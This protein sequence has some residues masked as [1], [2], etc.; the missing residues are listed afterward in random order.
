MATTTNLLSWEDFEK[1]P[2]D[3]MRR[4][5]IRGELICL[6]PPMPV[7]EGLGNVFIEGGSKLSHHPP[8]WIQ[9]DVSFYRAEHVRL[10]DPDGYMGCAPELAVEIISA[11]DTAEDVE[12][13]LDM[14]LASGTRVVWVI[15]PDKRKVRVFFSDGSS[16]SRG[17]G[18]KL[19][20]PELLPDW[21]LP[22]AKLFEN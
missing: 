5:L 11:D 4:E 15:Y 3:A 2:G 19:T 12:R 21:E 10:T 16:F 13:K 20:L 7:R 1:T 8:T 22:V 17:I 18:E 6:P 9:P 14:L